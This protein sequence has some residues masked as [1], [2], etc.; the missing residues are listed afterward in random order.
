MTT[1]ECENGC[2]RP[3]AKGWGICRGCHRRTAMHLSDLAEDLTAELELTLTG[4]SRMGP[5]RVGRRSSVT[6]L[7]F[8]VR[9]SAVLTDV[10]AKLVGWCLLLRDEAGAGLPADS[11][12]A[13]SLHLLG[14]LDWLAKHP[15]VDEFVA[16]VDESVG[17]I[18]RAIDLPPVTSR[19]FVGPCPDATEGH[20]PCPG[21]LWARFPRDEANRPTI[22]CTCCDAEYTADQWARLGE[23]VLHVKRDEAARIRLVHAIFG[24]GA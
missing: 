21:E 16:E 9:A 3:A 14:W 20:E 6:A 10:H 17:A 23:R 12:H 18:E 19:V 5:D 11:I 1:R 7:P 15:A 8:D 24:I 13:M 22:S 2:G 4:Q